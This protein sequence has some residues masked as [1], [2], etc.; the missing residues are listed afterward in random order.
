MKV[1]EFI[2]QLS[3]YQLLEEGF[4]PGSSLVTVYFKK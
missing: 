4:T 3:N 1:V 2:D